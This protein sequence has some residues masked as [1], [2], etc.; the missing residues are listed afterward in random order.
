MLTK[1]SLRNKQAE[2]YFSRFRLS[3]LLHVDALSP[4]VRFSWFRLPPR[5]YVDALSHI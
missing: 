1:H 3:P 4:I 5:L 2:S